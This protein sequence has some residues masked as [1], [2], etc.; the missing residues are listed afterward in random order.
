MLD[1]KHRAVFT[2]PTMNLDGSQ[3]GFELFSAYDGDDGEIF[4]FL[5]SVG[6]L[7]RYRALVRGLEELL[8]SR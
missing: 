3:R 2:A 8:L 1:E 4:L 6:D 7:R 5:N